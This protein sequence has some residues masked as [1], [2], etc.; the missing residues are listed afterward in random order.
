MEDRRRTY[1]ILILEGMRPLGRPKRRQDNEIIKELKFSGKA[2][3]ALTWH[4]L[5]T[6]SSLL[7]M[8]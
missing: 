3:T 5:E 6:S 7:P 8:Q 4:W 1:R 2:W